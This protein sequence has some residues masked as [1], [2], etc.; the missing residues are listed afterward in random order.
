MVVR[1][2]AIS[3]Q[4]R[5]VRV[6]QLLHKEAA[7]ALAELGLLNAGLQ[8]T[9]TDVILKH[10]NDILF[11]DLKIEASRNLDKLAIKNIQI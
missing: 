5:D 11:M 10:R 3:D 2:M 9:N 1:E 6:Y 7:L 4:V 8:R